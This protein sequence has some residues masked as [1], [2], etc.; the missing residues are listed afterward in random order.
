VIKVERWSEP[1][2][3][4]PLREARAPFLIRNRGKHVL[5]VDFAIPTRADPRRLLRRP[6]GARNMRPGLAAEIG[7]S[8]SRS[9]RF[10]DHRRH[11]EALV[12]GPTP[13]PRMDQ[14]SRQHGLMVRDARRR[15]P[16]G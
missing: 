5:P 3:T 2:V 1:T 7:L 10:P 8:T 15:F 16:F 6:S 12:Q 13:A 14:S 4:S 9:A 11:R